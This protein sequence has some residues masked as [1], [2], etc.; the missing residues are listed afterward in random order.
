MDLIWVKSQIL[1]SAR[2]QTAVEYIL[3]LA[4]A[5]SLALT[6]YRSATYQKIFGPNGELGNQLKVENEFGYRP[7]YL[8]NRPPNDTEKPTSDASD[9]PSYG[10]NGRTRFFGP[11]NIYP[12]Q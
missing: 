5:V 8:R 10:E 12:A 4:V 3:L 9:H 7:A 6:F 2:G 1:K 11:R